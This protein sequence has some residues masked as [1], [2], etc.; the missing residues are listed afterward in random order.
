METRINRVLKRDHTTREKVIQRVNNQLSDQERIEKSQF[1]V[2]NENLEG[3]ERQ[4]DQILILLK[5]K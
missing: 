5:N 1:I 4:I 2:T 3:T